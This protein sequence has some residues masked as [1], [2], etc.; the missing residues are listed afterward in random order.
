MRPQ[1]IYA[2]ALILFMALYG[3]I[4][5][6]FTA[7]LIVLKKRKRSRLLLPA[8]F[9]SVI[10]PVRNEESNIL[11]I[12][13]EIRGQNFPVK[14]MEVIV[15]DDFSEDATL[16]LA[17]RFAQEHPGFPLKLVYPSH[18]DPGNPGKKK[19]IERAVLKAQGEILLFTD[20][21]TIRGSRWISSMVSCFRAPIIQMVM[22]PVYFNHKKNLLQKIQ[23]LEFMGLMGTTAGSAALGYPVMCN[24]ANLAYKHATFLQTGGFRGNQRYGSGDDQFMMSAIRK[25]YGKDSVMFNLDKRSEVGTEAEATLAGFFQQRIR[26]VSKSRGYR[27][28]VVLAVGIITYV[29]HLL[30]L[31][32]ILLGFL[33]PMLLSLSLL[34]W[35]AK[36]LVE[37]PMVWLMSRFFGKHRLTGYYLPAQIFQLVYVPL[38]G[39]LGLFLPYR[40]KGRKG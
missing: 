15:T 27:D 4:I 19:A 28:P 35:V 5:L 9:V 21:D 2:L 14:R 10:I 32:G 3:T 34:L 31:S 11:R 18:T 22:G 23:S 17:N 13:E 26:W 16:D 7:G 40:W 29:T 33:I 12:L 39:M 25:I 1:E 38:A 24:G 37:Y 36:I 20:A 8:W 6:V 30:L